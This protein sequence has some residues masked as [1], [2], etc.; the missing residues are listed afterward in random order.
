MKCPFCGDTNT[1]VIDSRT[2]DGGVRRRRECQ[3]CG[4]RCTTYEQVQ[5]TVVMVVKKDGRREEFQR[6][7]LLYGLRVAA[8]KRP[9]AAGAVEA[10]VDN[11]EGRLLSC[12]RAEVPSRVIGEMAITHLKTLDPIAYIRFAS[13]YR[14]FVS[15][16]DMLAELSQLADAPAL[17]AD[18]PR[19]FEDDFDRLVRGEEPL[20]GPMAARPAADAAAHAGTDAAADGAGATSAA[21][22]YDEPRDAHRGGRP[23]AEPTAADG[24]R[25]PTPISHAPSAAGR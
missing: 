8:R 25:H 1:K 9:L 13:V 15:L 10:V 19:L 16:D 12:G 24:E 11:I 2:T 14:Q 5:S 21:A 22:A 3:S 23:T 6:E 7:K 18:Q 17:G 4:E 20:R